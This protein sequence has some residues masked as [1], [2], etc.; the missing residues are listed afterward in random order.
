MS[1]SSVDAVIAALRVAEAEANASKDHCWQV[2]FAN[3]WI[4]QLPWSYFGR[5]RHLMLEGDYSGDCYR[6]RFVSGSVLT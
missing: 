5:W 2:S 4:T 1:M 6:T 3:R